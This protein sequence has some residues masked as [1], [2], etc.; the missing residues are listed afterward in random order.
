[1]AMITQ[2]FDGSFLFFG[3]LGPFVCI[4]RDDYLCTLYRRRHTS[5]GLSKMPC[6]TARGG[7]YFISDGAPLVTHV[8]IPPFLPDCRFYG[9][10][11]AAICRQRF[12]SLPVTAGEYGHLSLTGRSNLDTWL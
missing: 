11:L 12:M 1:M 7:G 5:E 4:I 3:F 8:H 9:K 6:D 2:S 10:N